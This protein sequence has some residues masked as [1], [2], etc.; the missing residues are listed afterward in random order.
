MTQPAA[1]PI[2]AW[3]GFEATWYPQVVVGQTNVAPPQS[4]ADNSY[5]AVVLDLTN[6]TGDPLANVQFTDNST[7]PPVLAALA[8][9]AN[10]LMILVTY[11][12]RADNVPQGALFD[13]LHMAG[14]GVELNRAEQIN[15]QLGT[16]A[17][18]AYAYT[19]AATLSD[20]DLPGIETFSYTDNSIM[21][22]QLIPVQMPDGSYVYSPAMVSA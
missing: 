21:T 14:A 6:P 8:G 11:T 5:W 10:A 13:F 15:S 4:F 9:Q 16:G 20:Q 22:L 7:V 1:I 2:T 17:F 18:G 19:L 12:L 3:S